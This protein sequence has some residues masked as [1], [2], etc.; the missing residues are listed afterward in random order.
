MVHKIVVARYNENIEWLYPEKNN[1]IVYNKGNPLHLGK[2]EIMLR[3]IGRES[4]SYLRYITD[5]YDNLPDVVIFTQG[6]ISDHR[7][8]NDVQYLLQLKKE[9][10]ICGKSRPFESYRISQEKSCFRPDFNKD[11][12][13]DGWFLPNNYKNN[14][15]V[16][17]HIWFRK[18]IKKKYPNPIHVYTNGIFAVRKD[19]ILCRP[20]QF[21]KNMLHFL[22]HHSNPTEGHF[23]ER[24]W[25]YIFKKPKK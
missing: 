20:K 13:H 9:A 24:S 3:N 10:K 6:D 8:N 1:C 23:F 4:H 22:N 7:G 5:N 11:N 17:F 21:Y 14:V 2:N 25:F 19:F 18:F 15:R 12:I 16:L